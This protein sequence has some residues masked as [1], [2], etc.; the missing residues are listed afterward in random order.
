MTLKPLLL[1]LVWAGLSVGSAASQSL[2]ERLNLPDG[3]KVSLFAKVPSAREMVVMDEGRT[4]FVSTRR[5]RVYRIDDEDGDGQGDRVSVVLNRQTAPHGL[6]LGVDGLLYV[7]ETPQITRYR[8]SEDYPRRLV[9]RQEVYDQLIDNGWH[10]WRAAEFGPDDKLYVAVGAPC[11]ICRIGG[12]AGTIIRFDTESWEPEVLARGVRNSVGFDWQPDT[13]ILYFT[14]NGGDD[15]GDLIPPDEL[16][17]IEKPDQ[18]FGFP[19]VWGSEGKAYP[20]FEREEVSE[21]FVS[22]VVEFEAH[23]AALGMVFYR[24]TM[25]PEDYRGD[26]FVVQHGSWNR[27]PDDPAGYRIMR[28]RFDRLGEPIGKDVFLDGFLDQ[29]KEAWGRPAQISTLPDGSLLISDD[30]A[31]AIYRVTYENP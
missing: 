17:R 21:T 15:L 4:V 27:D 10:G 13:N 24:G 7:V 8:L 25:F 31:G 6:A 9:A 29:D 28:I 19:Y 30:F 3:F 20:G 11:N 16:N 23:A 1:G 5:D 18:H 22:P 12:L 2:E 26:A 14:D